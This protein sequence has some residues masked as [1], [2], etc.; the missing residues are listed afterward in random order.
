MVSIASKNCFRR[1]AVVAGIDADRA[2]EWK[3]RILLQHPGCGA[4]GTVVLV[5][6]QPTP[7]RVVPGGSSKP[8][9]GRDPRAEAFK[10]SLPLYVSCGFHHE[11]WIGDDFKDIARGAEH[12][13]L[14]R[15]VFAKTLDRATGPQPWPVGY[16]RGSSNRIAE[17]P[18]PPLAEVAVEVEA[19][20]IRDAAS[21]VDIAA[22][23]RATLGMSV[24]EIR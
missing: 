17:A 1:R 24:L 21:T 10:V 20:E 7:T 5:V 2:E 13:E 12:I 14:T 19:L 3:R 9:T 22:G 6:D 18:H 23:D 4:L 15:G 8:N 16:L 11:L